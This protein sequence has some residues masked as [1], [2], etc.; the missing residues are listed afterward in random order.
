MFMGVYICMYCLPEHVCGEES[1][2]HPSIE[3]HDHGQ[4]PEDQHDQPIGRRVAPAGR[5]QAEDQVRPLLQTTFLL[6]FESE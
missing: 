2:G 3:G 4:H 5:L 1:H 6:P